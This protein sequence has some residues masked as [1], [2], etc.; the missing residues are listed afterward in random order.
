MGK[1][2]VWLILKGFYLPTLLWILTSSLLLPTRKILFTSPGLCKYSE[3]GVLSFWGNVHFLVLFSW[4]EEI[5]SRAG[6][7]SSRNPCCISVWKVSL[8]RAFASWSSRSYILKQTLL[9]SSFQPKVKS[10]T[11]T[12]MVFKHVAGT[13]SQIAWTAHFLISFLRSCY[14]S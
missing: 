7:L 13:I 8:C 10:F 14:F 9:P 4:R 6:F 11:E 1:W 2:W 12:T 5:K 3:N